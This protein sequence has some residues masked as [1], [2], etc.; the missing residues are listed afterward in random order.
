MGAQTFTTYTDCSLQT[1]L[2]QQQFYHN[3]IN[4]SASQTFSH[5]DATADSV[6]QNAEP[7][8]RVEGFGEFNFSQ[9]FI[10]TD[11]ATHSGTLVQYNGARDCTNTTNMFD[12]DVGTFD[13]TIT[14]N[15]T[16]EILRF[17]MPNRDDNE[18]ETETYYLAVLDADAGPMIAQYVSNCNP[19]PSPTAST[20]ASTAS[21]VKQTLIITIPGDLTT[22]SDT[23]KETLKANVRANIVTYG[24]LGLDDIEEVTLS[25][26]SIK[27]TVTF[28]ESV[29]KENVESAKTSLAASSSVYY[30]VGNTPVQATGYT[31][32]ST[33]SS[34]SSASVL[35]HNMLMSIS[36]VIMT[37]ALLY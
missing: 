23:E 4:P 3:G 17:H 33:G 9:R 27:A 6:C 16:C 30:A 20:T 8:F 19:T 7:S 5:V 22:L 26:G 18:A 21:T 15:G 11:C 29:S 2:P 36:F 31:V 37:L 34:D 25:A 14:E 1:E 13:E 24:N 10:F 32:S 35:K 28:K 12:Y